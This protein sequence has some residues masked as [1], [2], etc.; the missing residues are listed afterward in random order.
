MPGETPV[1]TPELLMV[2]T[3]ELLLVHVPP[4]DGDNVV[5]VPIQ[6]VDEPT[7]FTTGLPITVIDV[8]GLEIHPVVGAV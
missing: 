7:I 1:T 2:A 6:I 8:E 3:A 4:V 5:V